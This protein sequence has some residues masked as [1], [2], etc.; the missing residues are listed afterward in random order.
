[1]T[2][3]LRSTPARFAIRALVL[4]L[5]GS[6]TFGLAPLLAHA[7]PQGEQVVGGSATV[8]RPNSTTVAV[9][10]SSQKAIINWNSFSIG[11]TEKTLF[12]Q[13]NAQAIVLNRVVGVDPS[14]ILGTLKANGQVWLVNPN[15]IVFGKSAQVDVGGLLA[16][17]LDIKNSDFMAGKYKFTGSGNTGAMVTNAGRITVADTGLAALVAPGVENSGIITARLGKIQLASA[18]GFT[19]DLN[20]DGTFNFLLD[21]QVAQQLVR[22]DGT[23]PSAAITNSGSLIADGGTILLT[24]N[25]AKGIVDNAIDMSGY[26]IARGVTTQG[27]TIILDGGDGSVRVSGTLDATGQGRQNGGIIKVLGGMTDG[28]VNVSGT[29][30]ASTPNGGNGGFIETSAA[31][32]QVSNSATITTSAPFGKTGTWLIDPHDFTIASSG[33]DM[34][35]SALSTALGSTNVTLQS[36]GGTGGT[37]GNINVNDVV[38]WGSPNTLTLTAANNINVNAVMTVSAGAS[39]ALNPGTANGGDAAVASGALVMGMDS[40][41]N[42]LGRI[43][44]NGFSG[45]FSIK[46]TPYTVITNF[47]VAGDMSGTTLQGMNGNLSGHYALGSNISGTTNN[48]STWN[49][50]TG[51]SPIGFNLGVGGCCIGNFADFTGV[52]DGLGHTISGLSITNTNANS[53]GLFGVIGQNG[54]VRNLNIAD[55]T[56]H[57]GANRIGGLLAGYARYASISSVSV[58]GSVTG[59]GANS[60]GGLVGIQSGG[61]IDNASASVTVSDTVGGFY[62]GGLIGT[63]TG[64]IV[65]SH[66][67]GAVSGG[68]G[69]QL[70]GL[71]GN[72]GFN[73]SSVSNSYSTSHVTGGDNSVVGGL[74]GVSGGDITSSYAAG[75][76]A[77]GNTSQVGGLAG[78]LSNNGCAGG[79]YR[80][81]VS[82]SYATGSVTGGTGSYVGGLVGWNAGGLISSSYETGHI[83][84]GNGSFVGG[85]DGR[86]ENWQSVVYGTV[87]NSYWNS[88]TSGVVHGTGSALTNAAWEVGAGLTTAQLKSGVPTGFDPAVWAIIGPV[89]SGYPSLQWQI[90]PTPTPPPAPT[91]PPPTPSPTPAPTTPPAPAPTPTLIQSPSSGSGNNASTTPALSTSQQQVTTNQ[92]LS[93]T[94]NPSPQTFQ[95]ASPPHIGTP[96]VQPKQNTNLFAA[97]Q[98]QSPG[99]DPIQALIRDSLQTIQQDTKDLVLIGSAAFAGGYPA[100]ILMDKALEYKGAYDNLNLIANGDVNRVAKNL[101]IQGV[102][103]SFLNTTLPTDKVLPLPGKGQILDIATQSAIVLGAVSTGAVVHSEMAIGN[104]LG[105][106][107]YSS[108]AYT[109]LKT[110]FNGE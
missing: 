46:G 22:P 75:I 73:H 60:L 74:V 27:G 69:S 40:S 12:A 104:V 37:S 1:M 99:T 31:H 38:S 59:S 9:N 45:T 55:S 18:A 87:T 93:Q 8:A 70:G 110:F 92:V 61:T 53:V 62:Y 76:V 98:N 106:A 105:T 6:T 23:T 56:V 67:E 58:S 35:G 33:G 86:N 34:V 42:F 44:F 94:A 49:S 65:S 24:A 51:F 102:E 20:G 52:F 48:V 68:N 26:A 16:T 101:A 90:P 29:L 103:Q 85:I 84:A 95:V 13:S 109:A 96:A 66:A 28:T 10:Q 71:V 82:S 81:T 83:V 91:P 80:G 36:S 97:L 43:N 64:Q 47:G 77:G 54:A 15:G 107:L 7:N 21:K 30:D 17:T 41:G 5:F 19:V 32:V 88:E 72:V 39:L 4:N 78:S 14:S 50:G 2:R 11:A 57:V 79:C 89:N 100:A 63:T 3:P 108:G 25:A